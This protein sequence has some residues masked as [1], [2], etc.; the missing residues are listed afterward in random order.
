[1]G[2]Q[3]TLDPSET[4]NQVQHLQTTSQKEVGMTN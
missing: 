4:Y 3:T 1:M 2:I